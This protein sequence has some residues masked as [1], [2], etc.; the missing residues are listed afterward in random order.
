MAKTKNKIEKENKSYEQYLH[1]SNSQKT[2]MKT[3][4][5]A[6][7]VGKVALNQAPIIG[8]VSGILVGGFLVE[9]L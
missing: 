1:R 9:L 6:E 7:K 4:K 5:T 3:K 2:I 8:G